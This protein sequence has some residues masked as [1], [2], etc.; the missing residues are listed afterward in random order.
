[1]RGQFDSGKVSERG[2]LRPA[3]PSGG[4]GG[5]A[6][7]PLAHPSPRRRRLV[8]AIRWSLLVDALV[9][10][11]A[12][13]LTVVPWPVWTQEMGTEA[14]P[15]GFVVPE[16][17]LWLVPLPVCFAVAALWLGRG[18]GRRWLTGI[19]VALCAAGLVLLCKPA[20]QAWRLGGT[21]DAKLD[22]AFGAP[23][24]AL[25]PPCRPFSLAAAVV[26][27][28][29]APVAIETMQYA[30]GLL[31][32]FYRP[33]TAA[34]AT[35]AGAGAAGA[36]AA[37]AGAARRSP[38]P[39]VVMIHGGSW[40]SGNR[41]D[42]GTK[43]WLNDW[44]AGLGYAVASI[45]YRLSPQFKWPAQRD[46]LLAAIRFLREHAGALGIDADRLVLVGR[47]AGGQI[48]T[49][50]AYAD[51]IPGVVGI[52]NIY[53]PTDFD[54]T[55]DAGTR[56]SSIDHRYNLEEFLGGS[57][58][59]ARAAYQSASGALLVTPRA[60]PTL[61]LWGELDINVFLEQ[62]E[63]LEAKLAAA[64]VPHALVSLPW[65]GHA[66]D[67]VNFNTP[68]A[69]IGRYAIVRFVAAVTG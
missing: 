67:F 20:V 44:L 32:D 13:L 55:W 49:A 7:V 4:G 56:P 24:P 53:G 31:L 25:S 65:A 23:P 33:A 40:V 18:R 15:V 50:A 2:V 41:L 3:G 5:A 51:V 57:R 17:A 48:A 52:V 22:A 28:N 60:P 62:A 59:T 64:G 16:I 47:S 69:Q 8:S 37:G 36:G 38:R 21:L 1:M 27:R 6:R 54:L 46:D 30:D 35:A 58:E 29:P 61:I 19:T 34:G 14:W 10:A 26:P 66:F 45:D 68:G 39:C 12:G 9:L 43:R 63:L 11:S 42:G